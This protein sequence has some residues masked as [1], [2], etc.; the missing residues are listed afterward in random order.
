MSAAKPDPAAL[1]RQA[2]AALGEPAE[3]ANEDEPV[4]DEEALRA[5]ARA[6]AD[7]MK[8]ARSAAKKR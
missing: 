1:L 6:S 5:R 8:R 3:P 7:R 4:I 2:L